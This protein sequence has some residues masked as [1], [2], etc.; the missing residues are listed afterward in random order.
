M[1]NIA[2]NTDVIRR[3]DLMVLIDSVADLDELRERLTTRLAASPCM[4]PGSDALPASTENTVVGLPVV[5]RMTC[6]DCEGEINTET[7]RHAHPTDGCLGVESDV[8]DDTVAV[9]LHCPRCG[10]QDLYEVNVGEVWD[11]IA[12]A[13]VSDGVLVIDVHQHGGMD[14]EGAGYLCN[15]C[16]ARLLEPAIGIPVDWIYS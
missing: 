3:E 14:R 6:L 9:T 4:K 8:D 13:F 15:S 10:S 12:N 16:S 2:P 11:E 5:V 1:D 7:I